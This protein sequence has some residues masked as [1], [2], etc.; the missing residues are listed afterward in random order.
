MSRHDA[1]SL[2]MF[3]AAAAPGLAL[4]CTPHVEHRASDSSASLRPHATAFERCTVDEATYARVVADWLR[5]QPA[6]ATGL[7]SLSLGRAVAYPWLS[8]AVADAA[9]ATPGWAARVSRARGAERDKLAA[10]VL[11]D[12]GLL[13]RLAVP[14][15]GSR[16]VVTRVSFEKILFGRADEH[17]S[18]KS[19]GTVLVPFDAQLWLRLGPRN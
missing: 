11:L 8:T 2:L 19:G 3:C 10:A 7:T 12:P 14:F 13:R 6:G 9:L 5:N 1:L 18:T 17:T 16:Y 4:A 15:E